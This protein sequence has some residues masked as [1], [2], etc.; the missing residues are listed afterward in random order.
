MG[1]SK[2]KNDR[3]MTKSYQDSIAMLMLHFWSIWQYI[4][5][6]TALQCI[7]TGD[8]IMSLFNSSESFMKKGEGMDY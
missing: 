4:P 6:L 2:S 8:F 1:K 7:K 5:H 3:L